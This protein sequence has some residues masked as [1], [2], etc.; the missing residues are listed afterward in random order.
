MM[1]PVMRSARLRGQ[2]VR[3]RELEALKKKRE[4]QAA[5]EAKALAVLDAKARCF[6]DNDYRGLSVQDLTTLLA[7]YNIPKEK[8]KKSDMVTRWKEIRNNHVPPPTFE[9][10]MPQDELGLE[11]LKTTEIDMA[12]TALGRYAA[13]MK[14]NAVAS[15]LDFTDAEWESLKLLKEADAVER[16]NVAVVNGIDN[17]T[18]AS[19]MENER[20]DGETGALLL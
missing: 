13:L 10:W 4:Q 7:W 17:N 8:M 19:G 3:I 16:S 6:E 1:Q 9:R 18:W 11:Q 5:T 2:Q 12:E 14:R 20:I 15:V